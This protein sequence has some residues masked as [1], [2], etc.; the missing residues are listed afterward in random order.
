MIDGL[1]VEYRKLMRDG[2]QS[3]VGTQQDYVLLIFYRF[4]CVGRV[5][6]QA[7]CFSPFFWD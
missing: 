4:F 1:T 6:A 5:P 2:C 3:G 7:S